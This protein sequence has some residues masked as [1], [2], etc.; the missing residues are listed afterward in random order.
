MADLLRHLRLRKLSWVRSGALSPVRCLQRNGI[1]PRIP[2][3]AAFDRAYRPPQAHAF[4]CLRHDG[5]DGDSGREY[6]DRHHDPGRCAPAHN[7]V[8]RGCH[9]IPVRLQ[10][11]L[12]HR[13]A[14]NDLA[15]PGRNHEPAHPHSS[16]RAVDLLQLAVQLL[17][18]HDHAARLRQPAVEDLPNVRRLQR[19]HLSLRVVLLPRAQGPEPGGARRHLR[20][21]AQRQ[22]QPRQAGEGHA[23]AV[24]TTIGERAH[25]VLRRGHDHS[26]G[27]GTWL[28][29]LSISGGRSEVVEE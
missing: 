16:Q 7:P 23:Q 10:H 14:G 25:Q 2:D 3:C 13:L 29:L 19:G 26:C 8:W 4:R 6:L 27:V 11:F 12:R 17:D 18:R 15:I 28:G 21:R 22:G 20:E 9:C 5:F 24:R 1:F